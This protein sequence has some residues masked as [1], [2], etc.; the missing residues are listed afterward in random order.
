VRYTLGEVVAS[1]AI[2]ESPSSTAIIESKPPAYADEP[3][4]P[5]DKLEKEFLLPAEAAADQD[6]E[7]TVI[8]HKP[9][10][11]N[12]RSSIGLLH[13]T[14]G[15]FGRW[16]GFGL[17]MF[18]H[19]A[20]ALV[21][22]GL[23]S[24]VG[25]G[26]VGHG[27][28][29]ILTSLCT[30]RLHMA[31]THAMIAAPSP[32]PWFRRLVPRKQCKAVLLPTLVF[33]VAQQATVILPIAVAFALG[34]PQQMHN[35]NMHAHHGHG[36]EAYGSC[37]MRALLMMRFLAVPL[38]AIFTA[39]C[40]LLPATV[41][42]TRIEAALLPEDQSTIVPFD[43]DAVLGSLDLSQRGAARAVFVQA[44][45]SF[46][47]AARLRLVKLYAKTFLVII[48]IAVVGSTLMGLE[49]AMIGEKLFVAAK[50]GAA[51]MQ[52]MAIEAHKQGAN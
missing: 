49:L 42:L 5:L 36:S 6:V 17:S 22:N 12:I 33:A 28:T 16:R 39:L 26:I 44:W 15:F 52:L 31:W 11:A 27:L 9:I 19:F 23:A 38:T 45:R 35:G 51:Q 32:K 14:G 34:L 18:Y 3:D 2:I 25:F 30:A 40:V 43:R 20:H 47:R 50:S 1:L 29:S 21:A 46:D 24:L 48:T 10:T 8:D 41:T 4:A 7:I 37:A 13:R